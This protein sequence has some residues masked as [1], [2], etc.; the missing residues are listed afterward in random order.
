MLRLRQGLS[1]AHGRQGHQTVV[2][3][4][5]AFLQ[6]CSLKAARH[7]RLAKHLRL[8]HLSAKWHVRKPNYIDGYGGLTWDRIELF[9]Q[10]GGV[11][12]GSASEAINCSS[13]R[14]LSNSFCASKNAFCSA[15]DSL[16]LLEGWFRAAIANLARRACARS[17][18]SRWI[19]TRRS[20]PVGGALLQAARAANRGGD[21]GAGGRTGPSGCEFQ[22]Q[23]FG[24]ITRGAGFSVVDE[25]RGGVERLAQ[26]EGIATGAP[27]I[28]ARRR[29]SSV[30]ILAIL[31]S[32]AAAALSST[33]VGM[34]SG[35]S[36]EN[37]PP[38][39]TQCSR[40]RSLLEMVRPRRAVR[41]LRMVVRSLEV[42]LS[43]GLGDIPLSAGVTNNLLVN[44]C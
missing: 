15:T 26:G 27:C 25:G 35:S 41:C 28:C 18:Y 21:S 19:T 14:E 31:S 11:P 6:S 23:G 13:V 36:K 2:H 20:Y 8:V 1:S 5:G 42:S 43:P 22:P 29:R 24:G 32:R 44:S 4:I 16:M 40:R 34:L 12:K 37:L 38:F 9:I 17:L 33:C 10:G 7:L 3:G 39:R 30:V